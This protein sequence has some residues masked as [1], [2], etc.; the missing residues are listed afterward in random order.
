MAV[1]GKE[2][3]SE[4]INLP[5]KTFSF[6]PEPKKQTCIHTRKY[7]PLCGYILGDLLQTIA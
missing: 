7:H 3:K 4:M 1:K 6:F 5:K 2:K